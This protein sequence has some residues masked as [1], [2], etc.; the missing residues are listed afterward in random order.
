[1]EQFYDH[2]QQVLLDVGFLHSDN[3]ERILYVIRRILSRT[4][5]DG[6]EL[7]ILRGIVRQTH[8]ALQQARMKFRK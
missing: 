3:P 5:L 2:F 6:R 8:W 7:K 4:T 1:M